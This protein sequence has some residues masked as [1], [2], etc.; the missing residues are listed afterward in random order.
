MP[1]PENIE[2]AK[3]KIFLAAAKL[4]AD[5]GFNAASM[6]EISEMSGFS[7]PTIYYYFGSK[8][9]IYS[10]LVSTSIHQILSVV[11]QV[12]NLELP[13]IEKLRV[14]A[15]LYFKHTIEHPEFARFTINLSLSAENRGCNVQEISNVTNDQDVVTVLFKEGIEKGELKS[16]ID[17]EVAAMTY[18]GAI[19]HYT[20]YYLAGDS[21]KLDDD[22][23]DSIVDMIVTGIGV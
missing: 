17:P 21:V 2:S 15:K 16:N 6:R 9:G 11:E 14:F 12:N 10:E 4:F 3:K 18:G 20:F 13:I 1:N 23:A 7:K 22:L 8:E 19:M 5:K